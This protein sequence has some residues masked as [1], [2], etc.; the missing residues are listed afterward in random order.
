MS[1]YA[2]WKDVKARARAADPRTAADAPCGQ[3]SGP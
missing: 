1:D 2:D 3:G